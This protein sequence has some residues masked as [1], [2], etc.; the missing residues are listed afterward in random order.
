MHGLRKYR[1]QIAQDTTLSDGGTE[2]D[3]S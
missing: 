2:R 3:I 1:D